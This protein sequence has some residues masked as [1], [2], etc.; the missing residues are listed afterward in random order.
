[1]K[2]IY[3]LDLAKYKIKKEQNIILAKK[4]LV[5]SIYNTA[6]TAKIEGCNVTYPDTQTILAGAVINNV[7]V[8]D[9]QTIVNVHPPI[10]AG[11]S[12][13]YENGTAIP[14][15]C[16]GLHFLHRRRF[17]CDPEPMKKSL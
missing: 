3:N 5:S 4:Y 17:P 10:E 11:T 2:Q 7:S 9:I 6:N 12:C 8:D 16:G 1:M 14:K 13:F 15:N